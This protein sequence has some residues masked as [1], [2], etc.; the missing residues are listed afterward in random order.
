MSAGGAFV[1]APVAATRVLGLDTATAKR[2]AFLSRMMAARDLAIGAGA[3]VAASEARGARMWLL[4]GAVADAADAVVIAAAMRRGRLRGAG[5]AA[6]VAVAACAA[7]LGMAEA[8]N[9]VRHG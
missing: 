3:V 1:V 5:P 9:P 8:L 7:G 4:A 6:V 2:V